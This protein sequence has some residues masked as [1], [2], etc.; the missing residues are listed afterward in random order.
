MNKGIKLEVYRAFHNPGFWIALAA[1]CFIT[2]VHFFHQVLPKSSN[3][4]YGLNMHYPVTVFNSILPLDYVSFYADIYYYSVPLLIVLPFGVSYYQD[5]QSGYR[6]NICIKMNKKNYL[7]GKYLAVFLSAGTVCV[8]PLL[9]NLLLTTT[10]IPALIPQRGTALFGIFSWSFMSHLFYTKPFLY[11]FFYFLLDFVMAGALAWVALE[12]SSI[13]HNRYIVLFSPFVL[14]FMLQ[15]VTE[16]AGYGNWNPF[17]ILCPMAKS[18]VSIHTVLIEVGAL[19]LIGV[20]CF[21]IEGGRK[22]VL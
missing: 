6:K 5:I 14:F 10:V 21:F 13:V 17:N 12:V 2:V 7:A 3:I 20:I 19:L 1:G 11:L 22:D 16:Y 18:V 8:L 15:A 4:F 9:L